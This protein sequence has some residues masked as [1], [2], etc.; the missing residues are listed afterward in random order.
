V[1]RRLGR[2]LG[3]LLLGAAIV[4]ATG[5]QVLV[6]EHDVA[7]SS[8]A[9][10][11]D[12]GV[13]ALVS[14]LDARGADLGR[15]EVVPTT[16]HREASALAPY[17]NLARGWNRQA[18]FARNPL[19]YAGNELT[20]HRYQR[21]LRSL[22][23]RFVVLPTSNLDPS[24]LGEQRLIHAGVPYLH[25]V[26][27]DRSW[28]LFQVAEP[29]PM[30]SAPATL[31]HWDSAGATVS[32]PVA[33]TTTLRIAWSPWLS[34]VDDAGHRLDGTALGGS[35]LAAL[36]AAKPHGLSRVVLH[37]ARPGTYRIAAPYTLPRGSA[38]PS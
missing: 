26:W 15:V 18:D 4:A 21:W 24:G 33:G 6:A 32:M 5:W 2:P 11:L 27:S 23:V 28:T 10:T 38:C 7:G 19:F 31:E 20:S 12:G 13:R 25:Q 8:S 16:S 9:A 1:A 22:A 37:A 17:V 3:R 36:P 29:A 35:C 30:V 34:L 14:Q